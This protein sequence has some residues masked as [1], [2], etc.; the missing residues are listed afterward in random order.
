MIYSLLPITIHLFLKIFNILVV[1]SIN[2]LPSYMFYLSSL[3]GLLWVGGT[4]MEELERHLRVTMTE[5]QWWVE[6]LDGGGVKVERV[7]AINF[8][9]GDLILFLITKGDL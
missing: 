4:V 8:K 2:P 9:F 7:K 6:E 3:L 1:S 5:H